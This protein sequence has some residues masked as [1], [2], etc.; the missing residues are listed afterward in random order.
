M[1]S[2][3]FVLLNPPSFSEGGAKIY[4]CGTIPGVGV[5]PYLCIYGKYIYESNTKGRMSMK[6]IVKMKDVT[7]DTS[8]FENYQS[9]TVLDNL[10]CYC[11]VIR[12]CLKVSTT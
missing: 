7:F 9:G 2:C 10:L 11:A 12:D 6:R 3:C 5:P 8:L 1:F 4:R